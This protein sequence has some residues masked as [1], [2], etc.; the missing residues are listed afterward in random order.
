MKRELILLGMGWGHMPLHLIDH[1]LESGKL[2]S[3]EG[4]H[5]Q[6]TRLDIVAARLRG[7]PVGPVAERRWTFLGDTG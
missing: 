4:K 6:R 3:I 2:L 7:R 1:D 5:F